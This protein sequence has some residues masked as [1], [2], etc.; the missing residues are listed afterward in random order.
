MQT[1]CLQSDTGSGLYPSFISKIYQLLGTFPT[2]SPGLG[3]VPSK[4]NDNQDKPALKMVLL[5]IGSAS[6]VQL[7]QLSS[8][9]HRMQYQSAARAQHQHT[10]T[11][12]PTLT[13]HPGT[14][15]FQE[16]LI[17]CACTQAL[18]TAHFNEVTLWVQGC[19]DGSRKK[20]KKMLRPSLQENELMF[21]TGKL[22]QQ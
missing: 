12:D 16:V 21:Q 18:I 1:L 10:H 13:H 17:Q 4:I 20:K 3:S 7:Q 9:S 11:T 19:V 15:L 2:T 8:P 6:L 22:E 14:V 5:S